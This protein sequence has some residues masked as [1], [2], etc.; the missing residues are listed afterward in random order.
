MDRNN[1]ILV[2]EDDL[3]LG[4]MDKLEAHEK[5]ILHRAF[6]VFIYNEMGQMLIHQRA[7]HKYHGAGLWTNA[8]C[9]HPQWGEDTKVSALQRLAYEMGLQCDLEFKFSF[10]YKTEVENNL[11][12]HEF[13]H[14]FMGVT[15][16]PP[17]PNPEEVKDYKWIYPIE[18]RKDIEQNP[19]Q[20]TF[21]F[22]QILDMLNTKSF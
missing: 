7:D 3:P 17:V 12:E 2:D 4:E 9:S 18:L 6:S 13:D 15:G 21:W 14:V 22:K 19:S 1:V 5:G 10:L 16:L 20:Y 8:C 11:I